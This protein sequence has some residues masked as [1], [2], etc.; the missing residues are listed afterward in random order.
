MPAADAPS[1]PRSTMELLPSGRRLRVVERGQGEPTV[2]FEA[3]AGAPL[4]SWGRVPQLVAATTRTVAYDRAGLGESPAAEGRRDLAALSTD[5]VQLLDHLGGT[6]VLAGHSWGGPIVRLAAAARPDAV[7]GVVLVDQTDEGCDLFLRPGVLRQQR[8]MLRL[9]PLMSRVGLTGMAVRR[10]ART[11]SDDLARELAR[12]SS[13]RLAAATLAAEMDH[14]EDDLRGLLASP[15][16]LGD[17]PVTVISGT[18]KP[19]KPGSRRAE[20]IA[21]H[22]RTAAAAVRGRHVRAAASDH[23]VP[24]TEPE[25]VAAE[26]EALVAAARGA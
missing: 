17:I 6:F 10:G 19:G 24:F 7:R 4:L 11:E 21:A 1:G 14:E 20:L 25:L 5:L 9:L 13:T 3:G 22:Q 8:T 16:D 18:R 26:I 15:P 23:L 12:Q 2:V